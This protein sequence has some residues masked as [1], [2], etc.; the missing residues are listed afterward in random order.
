MIGTVEMNIYDVQLGLAV[1]V[2]APNGKYIVIDLGS[3]MQGTSNAS[4]IKRLQRGDIACMVITHPHL[5]H[6]SDIL[7]IGDSLPRILFRVKGFT[8]QEILCHAN[9][10]TLV[11]FQHYIN[12]CGMY[13]NPLTEFDADNPMKPSNYG[14]LKI[15]FWN[16]STCDQSNFNNF[17]IITIFEFE[18]IK[19]VV[20]GDNEKESLEKLMR[21]REFQDAIAGAYILVAP[22]HGR[23]SSYYKEF[24]SQVNPRLTIIS[25][26]KYTD[27]SA[28][29]EYS[30]DS[31]GFDVYNSDNHVRTRKCLTTRT[32]GDIKIEFGRNV[33]SESLFFKVKHGK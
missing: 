7:N 31:Q 19:I 2:K 33:Q 9:K 23:K 14:G 20:C 6:F 5:D 24:V 25:D 32:D 3:G 11:K 4:P 29:R 10:D 13:N 17:S 18:G 22:H 21:R 16:D 12:F 15:S 1:H 28:V 26:G 8:D 27:N 30:E